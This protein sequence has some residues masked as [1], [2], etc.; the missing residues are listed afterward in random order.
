MGGSHGGEVCFFSAWAFHL[1]PGTPERWRVERPPS[2]EVF[3]ERL[4]G[5][6]ERERAGLCD[7]ARAGLILI[8][9][10]PASLTQGKFRDEL[11]LLRGLLRQRGCGTV[12]SSPAALSWNGHD[13]LLG[14]QVVGFVV[15][16]SAYRQ[17]R[18]YV[19]PNPFSYATRSDKRLLEALSRPDRDGEL[20]VR[21]DERALLRAH[22]PETRLVTEETIEELVLRKQELVFKPACGYASRSL[23]P[24]AHVGRGRL[25]RLL[26]KGVEYV[27]QRRVPKT[28]LPLPGAKQDG[29]LWGDLRVWA[30][31]GECYLISG[32]GCRGSRRPGVLDLQPP[33]GW[34]PSCAMTPG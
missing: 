2:V 9:D 12:V 11:G 15:N 30:Y 14:G 29:R 25:R 16:R 4:V 10:D 27:A 23:L 21:P 19:A 13:L 1:P 6:I 33:G 3:N 26:R 32:R 28:P 20:G 31:R 18:V 5:M 17:G 7:E 22:I 8:L 34:L 24:S